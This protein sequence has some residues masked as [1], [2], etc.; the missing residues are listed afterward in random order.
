MSSRGRGTRKN[1][2]VP[3]KVTENFFLD[4][5]KR[6]LLNPHSVCVYPV[7]VW[8]GSVCEQGSVSVYVVPL[9]ACLD[10]AAFRQAAAWTEEI[11]DSSY[12]I[13]VIAHD[14]GIR[15]KAVDLPVNLHAFVG[16]VGAVGLDKTPSPGILHPVGIG[17]CRAAS[18]SL[19]ASRTAA[20]A[21]KIS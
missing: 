14:I 8:R 5:D 10:P 21:V 19:L 13:P 11:P 20:G 17:G 1:F 12:L 16:S 3:F 4:I 18:R 9:S 15:L 2:L 7:A 6:Q